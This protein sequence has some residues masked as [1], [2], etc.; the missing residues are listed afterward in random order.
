M[1]ALMARR[2]EL[3]AAIARMSGINEG[4]WPL[5]AGSRT[6]WIDDVPPTLRS[7]D[8]DCEIHD[9]PNQTELEIQP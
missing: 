9:F 3:S 7:Q 1:I 2:L 4:V 6:L 5:L 8:H